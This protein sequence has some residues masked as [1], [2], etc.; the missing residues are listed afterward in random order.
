[1]TAQRH[2]GQSGSVALAV[3]RDFTMGPMKGNCFVCRIC[4]HFAKECRKTE[5]AHCSK[6]VGK[7]R[8]DRAC[9]RQRVEGKIESLAMGP[10]LA[11]ADEEHG[12]ALT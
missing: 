6:F 9:K 2:K 11:T 10:T 4:R 3:K 8:I 5:T 1:M 7:S 12:A